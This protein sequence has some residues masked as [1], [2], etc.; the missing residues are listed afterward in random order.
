MREII[1]DRVQLGQGGPEPLLGVV[2]A[3]EEGHTQLG[4]GA[5]SQ[6]R[7]RQ[8]RGFPCNLFEARVQLFLDE[9]MPLQN[10]QSKIIAHRK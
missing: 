8:D 5:E 7:L 2:F 3:V 1:A 9:E 10:D 6:P 4:Q